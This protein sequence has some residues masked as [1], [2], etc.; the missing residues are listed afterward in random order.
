MQTLPEPQQPALG[1]DLAAVGFGT[2]GAGAGADFLEQQDMI[3]IGKKPCERR[4]LYKISG[5]RIVIPERESSC[6]ESL[7]DRV[8]DWDLRQYGQPRED[9]DSEMWGE[10]SESDKILGK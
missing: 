7:R 2:I 1:E 9:S 5:Y 3:K 4:Y 6:A 8:L 10:W